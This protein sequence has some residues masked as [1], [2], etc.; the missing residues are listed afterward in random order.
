MKKQNSNKHL[1]FNKTSVVELNQSQMRS[2]NG[3]FP[4][5]IITTT[6]FT[7]I[8]G[9]EGPKG[10]GSGPSEQTGPS[11]SGSHA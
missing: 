2:V 3:G 4:W 5:T 9:D 8:P 10:T 7:P 11:D 1:V 6:I